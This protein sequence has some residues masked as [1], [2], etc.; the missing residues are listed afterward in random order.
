MC[1]NDWLLEACQSQTY[2]RNLLKILMVSR[3]GWL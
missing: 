1:T 2:L 3:H